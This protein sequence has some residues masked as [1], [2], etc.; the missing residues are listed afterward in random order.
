MAG[1]RIKGITIEIGGDTTS[2]ERS[3]KSVDKSLRTT[4]SDLRDVNKLLKFDPKNTELLKQ[5][6][7]LLGKAVNE[8]KDRLEKLKEAQAQ[9]DENGVDK[10]SDEYK[11]LQREIIS[12]ELRLKDLIK[13]QQNFG[14]VASQ[15]LK[16]TGKQVQELGKKIK[17][18]GDDMTKKVTGPIVAVGGASL[19]AFNEVDKGLD[20]VAKKTGATGDDLQKLNDQAIE[21]AKTIPTS[22]ETAGEAIG[23]VNTRF[24]LTG[25]ALTDLSTQFVKFADIND[26]DVTS[27]VDGVQKAMTAYGLKAEDASG[28]LDTLTRVAQ[29][30]GIS[31]DKLESGLVS[32]AAAF[33]EMGLS[34]DQSAAF[35]GKL[36]LSGAD[37]SAVMSGLSKAL[38]NASKDG[39]SMDE[40]LAT[41][42]DSIKNGQSDAEGLAAAYE[43][44]G[45][46]GDQVFNAVKNGS[47]SFKDLGKEAT[48][49][50]GA[51][52]DTFAETK[53]PMENFQTVLNRFVELGYE[54]GN[55][56]MPVIQKAMEAIIPVIETVVG[57]WESLDEDTQSF[58]VTAALVV[59]A[60][61]PIISIIGTVT[62]VIGGLIGAIGSVIGVI[63]TV[64]GVLGGPL[65]IAIGAAIALGIALWK[66]WDTVKA[67]AGEL[68]TAIKTKWDNI[69]KAIGDAINGAKELVSKGIEK[70]K[71]LFNFEFKWPKLKMPHFKASG[72]LNPFDWIKNGV[73]K[74]EVDW[75]AKAA[76]QP[77]LFN[78]PQIIG[79]GD[80]PEVV[81]GADAFR[82]M[83]SGGS[84]VNNITI[85]QQPG[86]DPRAIAR[87]T[88][89]ELRLT[90]NREGRSL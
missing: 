48:D 45:K 52:S 53:S 16:E 57:W 62:G 85:V 38:K 64:V 18:V 26:T 84:I 55:A 89:N 28:F 78:S 12:T 49:A 69:K 33:Q 44:F 72:S 74:I 7:E 39:K 17:D 32:N 34:A 87:A 76:K 80:V 70:I 50:G 36:E 2:L 3:L 79:V 81:I 6:Q 54:I 77:Y 82:R 68:F 90:L 65:T 10:N 46:S 5:K 67:K 63:S 37:S 75:Y 13:A 30:T 59:A 29:N 11:G 35:M 9:M 22:F 24:G 83:Q 27:A 43:L 47:L 25:D 58:I 88:I 61:G 1:N 42:E 66:N 56:I 31:V 41:L 14:S 8:T 73:P 19:A 4:Q 60:I 40:A 71:S 23:E 86:Q 15:V 20:I 51:V 21:I